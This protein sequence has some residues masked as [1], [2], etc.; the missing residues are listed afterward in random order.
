MWTG[1]AVLVWPERENSAGYPTFCFTGPRFGY[2]LDDYCITFLRTNL[3]KMMENKRSSLFRCREQPLPIKET[4][5]L[6]ACPLSEA[7]S[8]SNHTTNSVD[9]QYVH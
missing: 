5:D 8:V 4:V 7:Y 3:I 9:S 1:L 2:K 6:A